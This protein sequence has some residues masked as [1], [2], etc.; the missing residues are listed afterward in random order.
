MT[1]NPPPVLAVQDDA[2]RN[3]RAVGHTA[4]L[5]LALFLVSIGTFAPE[6]A[7]DPG[8]ASAA[9]IRRFAIDNAGTIQVNTLAALASIPLLVTFVAVLAKHVR[10]VRPWSVGPS[11]MVCLVGI[12]AMQS[13]FVTATSSI[14]ALPNQLAAVTD[15]AVVTLYELTAVAQWLY[16]LTV[17]VPCMA[18]VATYSWLAIR[19]RLLAR[20]ICWAGFTMATVGAVTAVLL[21]IP[22]IQLDPFLLPL[23]GWWLWPA[24]IG[25]ASAVRWWRSRQ[26]AA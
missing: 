23:F 18:L 17:L 15:Q 11:V 4:L 3:R 13:L 9:D 8:T 21:M 5:S 12:V 7:P 10:Q 1:T 6:S 16:T 24:M 25:S 22:S 2:T 20:W 19:G 14:F 26:T